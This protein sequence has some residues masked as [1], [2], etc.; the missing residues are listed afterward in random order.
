MLQLWKDFRQQNYVWHRRLGYVALAASAL[1]SLSAAPY[2]VTYLLSAKIPETVSMKPLWTTFA[3]LV[4][5][6]ACVMLLYLQHSL[7][8]HPCIMSIQWQGNNETCKH[9]GDKAC[10][11]VS[12]PPPV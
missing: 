12:Y 3:L 1:G 4:T 9:K 7:S 5:F 2:A 8:L 6:G 11:I 10:V